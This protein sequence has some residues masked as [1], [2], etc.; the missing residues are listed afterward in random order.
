MKTVHIN[1][2]TYQGA[3]MT[4]NNVCRMEEMD[5]P[6]T[7]GAK[8]SFSMLRAYLALCMNTS[9]EN[10]GEELEKHITNGGSF[11]EL[12]EAMSEAIEN[13]DFFQKLQETATEETPKVE[14]EA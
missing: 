4:F 14:T 11:D 9:K 12:S 6:I 13:S 2:K 3:E 10:A 1:G 8:V 7:Y 5:A